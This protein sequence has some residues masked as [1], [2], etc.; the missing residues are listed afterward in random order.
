MKSQITISRNLYYRIISFITALL[1]LCLVV[2]IAAQ[3]RQQQR[4][5]PRFRPWERQVWEK[6]FNGTDLHNWDVTGNSLWKL[7]NGEIVATGRGKGWLVTQKSYENFTLRLKYKVIG[8]I[9]SGVAVRVPEEERENPE[10][11]GYKIVIKNQ[12]DVL[13]PSGSIFQLARG[14][15]GFYKEDE[16]NYLEIYANGDY[17]RVVLNGLISCDLIDRRS[18]KGMIALQNGEGG[19]IRF[20]D[21]ELQPYPSSGPLPPPIEKQ[22]ESAPGTWKELFN[23]KDLTGWEVMG[24]GNWTV[25]D[26]A[27]TGRWSERMGWLITEEEFSDFI[28]KVKFKVLDNGN[29]GM[30]IRFPYPKTE[31]DRRKMPEHTGYEC[32]VENINELDH[33]DPTGGLYAQSRAYPDITHTNDWNEYTIYALGDRMVLYVNGKKS[34]DLYQTRS[35]KGVIGFKV[36]P[37]LLPVQYKD[38]QIKVVK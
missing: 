24:P 1:V 32:Q 29:S 15:P 3:P 36:H 14:Y 11:T 19:E 12:D 34:S 30:C 2:E 27:I 23:G 22:L 10:E 18:S 5:R 33:R 37:P 17:I 28:L 8:T 26:G 9:S 6:I 16:W 31:E 7:E 25:E 35:Y 20:K 13:D 4:Q 21:I 38:I